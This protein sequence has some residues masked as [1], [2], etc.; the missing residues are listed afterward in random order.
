MDINPRPTQFPEL[1]DLLAGFVTSAM[2]VLDGNFVGA[3]LQGSFALGDADMQSDCD[4][5]VVTHGAVTADQEHRLRALHDEIP[6]RPGHW[7]RHLEGSYAPKDELRTLDGLG[8]DWLYIDHGWREM[9]W[10]TH[11]NTEVVRWSL[12]EC[13]VTLA[14]PA[15]ATLVD[16]V[17]AGVLRARMRESLKT[18][19]PDLLSWTSLDVAWS[20]RYAVATIC[21]IL[22]TFA[23]GRVA[24]KRASLLWASEQLDSRWHGLVKSA[25]DGRALGWDPAAKSDDAVVESTLRFL[26]HAHERAGSTTLRIP[27]HLEDRA[28]KHDDVR[29]WVERLPAMVDAAADR[30]S[31]DIGEPYEPGGGCGWVA[32]AG[33]SFVVKIALRDFESAHEA[34]G[35]RH[36]DGRGSVRLHDSYRTDDATVMLIERCRP[37]T[38]LGRSRPE[39]EQDVIVADLLRDLWSAPMTDAHPFR[40]LQVMCDQW[41]DEFEA[42]RPADTGLVRDALRIWREFSATTER[43]V[44]LCTD[45]HA[46]N[47]LAAER[48][49]WLVVD[50]KPYVGDPAYDALQHMLNCDGRLRADPNGLSDRMAGLLEVDAHRVRTWLFA[51]CVQ[52]S[53]GGWELLDVAKKIS[54]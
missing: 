14:G 22:Y 44:L 2:D 30:W 5:V 4:F 47:V 45:L 3:Y 1:N 13:G 41:A 48:E 28:A 9:Q 23:T 39:P 27:R 42:R 31:L 33:D 25:L 11:C 18:F 24:S 35:L 10:S 53:S 8:R 52:E 7:T 29:A 51:R 19:L 34:E 49:P 26:E 17:D 54:L 36:W 20:Q 32:P 6:A 37:G 38:T 21:R 16:P 43:E 46:A 15:P 40:P 12:R 50:P